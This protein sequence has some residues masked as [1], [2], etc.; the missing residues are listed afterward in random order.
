M[1]MLP[2]EQWTAQQ[3]AGTWSELFD[4]SA[5][6]NSSQLLTVL[7]WLAVFW[8]L[9]VIFMPLTSLIF[10]PLKDKGWGISKLFGLMVWGYAVWLA[11]SL[12]LEYSRKNILLILGCFLLLNVVIALVRRKKIMSSLKAIRKDILWTDLESGSVASV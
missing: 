11:S 2:L 12:G 1:E 4:R 3:A 8:L 7:I 9:G 6:V 5:F 10:R